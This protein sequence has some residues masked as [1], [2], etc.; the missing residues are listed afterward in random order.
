MAFTVKNEVLVRVYVVL[1]LIVAVAFGIAYR[2][3]QISV[4]EG[5]KWRK[6]G[7]KLHIKE[8]PVEAERGNIL[9]EDGSMLATSMPFFDIAFDPNSSAMDSADWNLHI[10]SLSYCIATFVDPSFTPGGMREYL[11]EQKQLIKEYLQNKRDSGSRYLMIKKDATI[12]EKDLISSF[13]LFNKGQFRGGLIIMPKYKRERPFGLLANRTIGYVKGDSINVGLEGYFNNYL[14]GDDGQALMY[15]V[16]NGMWIPLKDL[17]EIELKPGQDIVTTLDMDIQAITENALAKA[18]HRHQAEY[19]TAVVMEV[20]TGA[21]KAIANLDWTKKGKLWENYNHA[22]GT[23]CEPGS[24]FKLASMLALFEDGLVELNDSI[25]LEQGRTM[26]FDVEL[27]DASSH[28]LNNV[29]VERAFA[30]SSN[31]GISR[32]VYNNYYT[33]NEADK[34]VDRLK[35]FFLDLPTGIKINGEVAPYFKRPYSNEDQ[36]SGT[37]LPWMA[38]GYELAM[39][40][41]QQLAFYNAV[42]NGGIY[43]KPFLVRE[44][45]QYG[46]TLEVFPVTEVKG[47]IASKESIAKAQRL[48]RAVV[49]STYGTAYKRRSNRFSFAGKTGT[50]Q[51][52]YQRLENKTR[53][54]GYQASFAGY[55]PSDDPVYSCIVLI[56]KP[57]VG[58]YYGSQVALPVFKEIATKTFRT[59]LELYPMVGT[60]KQKYLN[61]KKMP[62][63]DAG[64][65]PDMQ[66]ILR[67]LDV[68]HY[69]RSDGDWTI[70]R[71][72]APD[73]LK[74]IKRPVAQT[75]VP[76]VLGMGL[77]DALFLLENKGL[78]VEING[79]YG[80]V[81]KQS[82]KPGAKAKG[83]TI[84]IR[85]G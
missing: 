21:I 69:N 49:D 19:G 40:P 5:E 25:D 26:Y 52:G 73:S 44:V 16:G 72:V 36:W 20:K 30:M 56:S 60:E 2:T 82:I 34:Y 47:R 57:K 37:T 63:Y 58:G 9:T 41:L 53:V 62:D 54:R 64:Y 43:V 81:Q 11:E 42:A 1:T 77:R 71:A 29:T 55:F 75:R 38:I 33:N 79:K 78:R 80:R 14:K 46:E 13:P 27:E 12:E 31:V 61:K 10:D 32:L 50:A 18:M 17:S 35:S 84:W 67:E 24:T 68:K 7:N 83:Q 51:L 48:L 8:V 85:L 4:V 3:F 28:T 66:E 45:Q 22:V 6:E 70:L 76:N 74:L 39:T 59:N 23:V 65:L 15:R